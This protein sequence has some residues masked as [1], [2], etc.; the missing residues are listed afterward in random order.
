MTSAVVLFQPGWSAVIAGDAH[1]VDANTGESLPADVEEISGRGLLQAALWN[2]FSEVT[3]TTVVDERMVLFEPPVKVRAEGS[4]Y[5]P[6][7]ECWQAITEGM[8][9]GIPG[10]APEYVAV[11]VRHAPELDRKEG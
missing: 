8:P 4:F 2:G 9:R 10:R 3:S 6:S 7:G 5:S 11:Q 1:E